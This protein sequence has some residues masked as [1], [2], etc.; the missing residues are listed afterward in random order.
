MG[1]QKG[2]NRL[3]EKK[4][5][6][7]NYNFFHGHKHACENMSDMENME[8]ETAKFPIVKGIS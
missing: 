4:S 3:L 1:L 6:F 2:P 7:E 5:Y 8:M